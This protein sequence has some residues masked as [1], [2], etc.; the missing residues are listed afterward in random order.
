[1]S[2]HD[3]FP[4]PVI[5]EPFAVELAN[6]RYEGA[7]VTV[8]FLEDAHAVRRWF[9]LVDAP[10]DVPARLTAVDVADVRSVRDAVRSVL[11]ATVDG[12]RIGRSAIR[13]LDHHA[14]RAAARLHLELDA[15]G[16]LRALSEHH[17]PLRDV[18]VATIASTCIQFLAGEDLARTRRCERP[19]CPMLF[20]QHHRRRRFCHESCAHRLRQARYARAKRI[21][22][23]D[24]TKHPEER[25]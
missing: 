9:A 18:F 2:S 7:D 16:N 8:D 6:S 22:P 19:G 25:P 21:H 4:A 13:I 12:G 1:M 3:Q 5:G 20:V 17:G 11:R 24:R 10:A 23:P 14:G 15:D